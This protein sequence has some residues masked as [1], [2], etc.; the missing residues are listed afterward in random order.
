M[1]TVTNSTQWAQQEFQLANFGDRRLTRRLVGVAGALAQAPTGTLPQPLPEWK[2]LKGAYRLFSNPRVSYEAI[3]GPHWERTAQICTEP[4]EYL[5]LEDKSELDFS[6]HPGAEGLGQIGNER[7]RGLCLHTSLAVRVEAWE[8]DQS[9]Q[10]TVVGLLEQKCWA[11]PAHPKTKKTEGWRQR[12]K[13]S[14][15]SAHWSA[16]LDRLP[17]KPA[18]VSWIY[19]A[20]RESDIY[21]PMEHCQR[22]GIGFIIRAHYDRVL[23]QSDQHL[24]AAVR[25]APVA[26]T[27]QLELRTRPNSP[28]RVAQL[29]VRQAQVTLRG[30]WRPDG[31]RPN[32]SLQVLEVVEVDPPPHVQEPIHWLLLTSLATDSFASVRRI[33][34]RYARRWLIEEYHKALKSGA[35]MEQ[36]RLESK[37]RLRALLGVMAVLAVRL[38]NTKLLARHRPDEPVAAQTFGP[39]ALQI[40]S[41]RFGEPK[42]GWTYQTLWVAIERLGGFLARKGDGQPGWITI[43]RGWDRLMTMAEGVIS[44]SAHYPG[45]G[46]RRCG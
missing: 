34:G 41:A 6:S 30:V 19:I 4:G 45:L 38:L 18:E 20:D 25:A 22:L 2:A 36:S 9:P 14:R 26:G 35:Q 32:L 31:P 23:A 16:S 39:E 7:G 44:L 29:A 15:E 40:L 24:L 46:G 10:V 28:A 43:W 8:L 5:I 27:Y 17:S 42:G 1:T 33:I 13:R 37:E 21:E 12:L 11:R 3:I